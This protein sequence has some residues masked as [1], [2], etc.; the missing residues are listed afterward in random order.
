MELF[1]YIIYLFQTPSSCY[2]CMQLNLS[3]ALTDWGELNVSVTKF[4]V[5][6]KKFTIAFLRKKLKNRAV[7]RIICLIGTSTRDSNS[8]H[9]GTS[10]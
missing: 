1:L 5:V 3:F 9:I 8:C 6:L 2:L 10:T 4:L 7:V